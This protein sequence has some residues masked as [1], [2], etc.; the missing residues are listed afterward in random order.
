[1]HSWTGTEHIQIRA[2]DTSK[3]NGEGISGVITMFKQGEGGSS[4]PVVNGTVPF[5]IR[6][7]QFTFPAPKLTAVIDQGSFYSQP[8]RTDGPLHP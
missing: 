5:M 3:I 4:M 8:L 7:A 6:G 2:T 1:M